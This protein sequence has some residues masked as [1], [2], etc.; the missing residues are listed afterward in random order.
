MPSA[1]LEGATGRDLPEVAARCAS[2]PGRS[3]SPTA[4]GGPS[5]RASVPALWELGPRSADSP[6]L[7]AFLLCEPI[8]NGWQ[9]PALRTKVRPAASLAKPSAP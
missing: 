5:L 6:A 9:L 2:R 1:R 3:V 4:R 7:A 8:D